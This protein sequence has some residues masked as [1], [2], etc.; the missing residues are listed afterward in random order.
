MDVRAAG[1]DDF[2]A[3]LALCD[4][5]LRDG[6][7]AG[8]DRGGFGAARADPLELYEALFD[9]PRRAWAWLA[10]ADGEAVG[11]A[12]ATAGCSLLHRRN[13]LRLES[14]FVRPR[15]HAP[16]AVERRLFLHVLRT[17]DALGCAN[18][19]WN[20]PATLAARLREALPPE[21]V[22]TGSVHYVLPLDEHDGGAARQAGG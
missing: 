8:T 2:T 21:A 3:L 17:A 19:Q 6:A 12:G 18:L 10:W 7:G 16:A 15:T 14:L 11:Y 13:Y 9:P 1:R 20:L 5:Q 22:R 4:A